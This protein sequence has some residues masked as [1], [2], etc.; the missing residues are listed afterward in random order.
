MIGNGDDDE[1][2]RIPGVPVE[3]RD[4]QLRL[5]D[6]AVSA[7]EA[8]QLTSGKSEDEIKKEA[9]RRDHERSEKFKDHFERI[10]VVGLY[11]MA[12]GAFAF[13]ATWAW[14]ALV[15]E[16]WGWLDPDRLSNIQNI[17]TGGVLAGLIA[18]QFRRRLGRPPD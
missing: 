3:E 5:S 1:I 16:C 11:V 12:G 17:V 4:A 8:V 9:L 18:D 13:A 10:T 14:H 2:K 15:P 7:D 6:A